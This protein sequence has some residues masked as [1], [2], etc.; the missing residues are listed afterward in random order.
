MNLGQKISDEFVNL[1]L[2]N[3]ECKHVNV[4]IIFLDLLKNGYVVYDLDGS[5]NYRNCK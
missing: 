5:I 1:F 2:L 4:A 3:Y